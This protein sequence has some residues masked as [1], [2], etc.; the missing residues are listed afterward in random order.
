MTTVTPIEG[1][2]VLV[3]GPSGAG[4]DSLLA[5][6][7]DAFAGTPSIVFARRI[8]T[9]DSDDQTESHDTISPEAFAAAE[10]GDA[11]LLSWKAHGL[12]YAI[13]A[14]AGDALDEG[15]TVV[16]NV[17]RTIIPVAV[18]KMARVVVV[19]VTAPIDLLARRIAARGRET[20]PEIEARLAR[21]PPLA[22]AGAE[23]VEIV[24]DG[25]LEAAALQFVAAIR[26]IADPTAPGAP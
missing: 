21:Q 7:R 14:S 6:A 22:T 18:R 19:H 17:S 1:T 13:P 23:V 20:V 15:R 12:G 5:A 25:G 2:M 10:A 9:R 3:V 11:F 4:K 16:A 24:N 26:R 8:I